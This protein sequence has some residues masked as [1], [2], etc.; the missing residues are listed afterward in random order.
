MGKSKRKKFGGSKPRPTGL[1]SV[2]ECEAEFELTGNADS[3]PGALQN[4]IEKVCCGGTVIMMGWH[5]QS[6]LSEFTRWTS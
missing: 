5:V 3:T 1:Q 4:I 6:R 2:S